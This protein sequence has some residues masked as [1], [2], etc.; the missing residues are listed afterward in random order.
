LKT[1]HVAFTLQKSH[2]GTSALQ[3]GLE[4]SNLRR[5]IPHEYKQPEKNMYNL[6]LEKGQ[7]TVKEI[8]ISGM[9]H[10]YITKKKVIRME[11]ASRTP[12]NA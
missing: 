3:R 8:K 10:S 5:N 7:P 11:S 4:A 1:I 2:T 9:K 6:L 12:V